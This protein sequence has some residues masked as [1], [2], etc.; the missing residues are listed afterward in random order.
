MYLSLHCLLSSLSPFIIS[1]SPWHWP[2]FRELNYYSVIITALRE[3]TSSALTLRPMILGQIFSSVFM[4]LPMLS[5]LLHFIQRLCFSSSS[6]WWYVGLLLFLNKF[7]SSWP[8]LLIYYVMFYFSKQNFKI[9]LLRFSIYI[10]E[11]FRYTIQ[12]SLV[13]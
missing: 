6:V 8:I 4:K 11:V 12:Q 2:I 7:L 5:F 9:S 10:S 3:V 1:A 13:Q